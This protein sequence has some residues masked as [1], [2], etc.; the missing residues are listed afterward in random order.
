MTGTVSLPLFV[1]AR[2]IVPRG[3]ATPGARLPLLG[4]ERHF[5]MAGQQSR[6]QKHRE[7]PPDEHRPA[8]DSIPRGEPGIRAGHNAE[9][10]EK[11]IG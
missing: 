11:S 10:S 1:R 8:K 5:C 2:G 4:R 6:E 7:Q 3:V 9:K